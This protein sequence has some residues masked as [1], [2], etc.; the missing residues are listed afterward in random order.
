MVGIHSEYLNEVDSES[1][2]VRG[3]KSSVDDKVNH[4]A[5][6]RSVKPGANIDL[7][8]HSARHLSDREKLV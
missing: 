5:A 2:S 7:L 1:S 4:L 6:Q 3:A 8:L